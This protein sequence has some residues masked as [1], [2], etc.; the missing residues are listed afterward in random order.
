MISTALS[1]DSIDRQAKPPRGMTL[2]RREAWAGYLFATPALLG[3]LAFTALPIVASLILIFLHYDLL[4]PAEWAGAENITRLAT[5]SRMFK[6]YW[7]S[8]RL[9]VGVTFLNNL[10]G[11]LLAVGLNRAM[12]WGIR[13]L[14]RTSIFFP[15]MT[16][17]A[18]LAVVWRFLLTQDRGV[19]NFLI[20]QIGLDPAPRGRVAATSWLSIWPAFRRFPSSIMK[21]P[22][23][24]APVSGNS[25]ATL[26]S[27]LS[28]PPPSLPS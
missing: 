19:V 23:S 8:L 17:T 24:T 28:H 6:I 7:N 26:P 9:V 12:P 13:Y 18:S 21:R 4:T 25:S 16:T 27:P 10:L 1:D 15:V 3:L 5:D 20:G 14:L 2:A 11:L 22:A